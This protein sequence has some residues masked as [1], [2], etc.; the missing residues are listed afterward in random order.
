V[1]IGAHIFQHITL[2]YTRQEIT[3][4]PIFVLF[5]VINKHKNDGFTLNSVSKPFGGPAA[6]VTDAADL[7]YDGTAF[8]DGLHSVFTSLSWSSTCRWTRISAMARTAAARL[9]VRL[10]SITSRPESL[11]AL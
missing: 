3:P 11:P 10:Y 9:N 1:G 2:G 8:A 5:Y 4:C 6:N 7:L